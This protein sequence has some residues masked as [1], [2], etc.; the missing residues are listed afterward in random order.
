MDAFTAI[1][2]QWELHMLGS[3]AEPNGIIG[4]TWFG[5]KGCSELIINMKSASVVQPLQQKWADRQKDKRCVWPME[6]LQSRYGL[7]QIWLRHGVNSGYF[8]KKPESAIDP[9]TY[10]RKRLLVYETQPSSTS[11]R[12][13]L[14]MQDCQSSLVRHLVRKSSGVRHSHLP[15]CATT[16]SFWHKAPNLP[17]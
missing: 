4:N 15:Q 5:Y 10:R 1:Q 17:R 12:E 13:K 2:N 6:Y 3:S 14:T 7:Y 11:Y 9:T 16:E 8:R